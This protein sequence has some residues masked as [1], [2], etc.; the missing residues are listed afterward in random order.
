MDKNKEM[1][2]VVLQISY[3]RNRIS[4]SDGTHSMSTKALVS[5]SNICTCKS[6]S[7]SLNKK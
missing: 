4:M 2:R 6:S 7:T 3:A 1:I 5:L